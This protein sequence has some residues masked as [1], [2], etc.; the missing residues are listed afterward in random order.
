MRLI[1]MKGYD[2]GCTSFSFRTAD[3]T[4]HVN[5]RKQFLTVAG[6]VVTTEKRTVK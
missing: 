4:R 3:N 6:S 2:F 5:G 1:V